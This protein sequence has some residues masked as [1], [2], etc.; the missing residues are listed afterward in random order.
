MQRKVNIHNKYIACVDNYALILNCDYAKPD[1]KLVFFLQV[2]KLY[3]YFQI[4][5]I[6][7]PLPMFCFANTDINNMSSNNIIY[8]AV[9][10]WLQ[11][12]L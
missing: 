6:V 3:N 12:I 2:E 5:T 1:K 8:V 10:F 9:N 4:I 11:L 7:I